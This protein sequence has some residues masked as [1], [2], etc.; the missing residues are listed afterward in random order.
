MSIP[1]IQAGETIDAS[2]LK[3]AARPVVASD[4]CNA[5]EPALAAAAS[6]PDRE[7][8]RAGTEQPWRGQWRPIHS[9][10][11]PK[12]LGLAG[13]RA[14]WA[15]SM[16]VVVVVDATRDG[17]KEVSD[18]RAEDEAG[19]ETNGTSKVIDASRIIT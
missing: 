7:R 4:S 16:Q 14:G 13:G 10:K 5:P 6:L 9:M 11:I 19:T 18:A 2:A 15:N 8:F 3:F 12:D 17:P 1:P